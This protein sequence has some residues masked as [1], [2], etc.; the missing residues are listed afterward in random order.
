MALNWLWDG[1][2][3]SMSIA[4]S[5]NSQLSG[6]IPW[7]DSWAVRGGDRTNHSREFAQSTAVVM[8]SD[9]REFVYSRHPDPRRVWKGG[10][11]QHLLTPLPRAPGAPR[12]SSKKLYVAVFYNVFEKCLFQ[13]SVKG[14]MLLRFRMKIHENLWKYMKINESTWKSIHT[15]P[16]NLRDAIFSEKKAPAAGHHTHTGHTNLRNVIFSEKK[17]PAA[18]HH[19]HTQGIKIPGTPFFPK[20]KRLRQCIT[21]TQGI[22]IPGTS[23]FPKQKRLRQYITHTHR[24]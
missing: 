22:K 5:P 15:G 17:A 19:T 13:F 21:H 24:A 8:D 10:S 11:E 20:K 2:V 3:I 6:Y 18:V 4:E 14:Y 9:L 23:V 1:F 7:C 12:A 16:T